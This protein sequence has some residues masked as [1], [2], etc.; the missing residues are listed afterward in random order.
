MGVSLFWENERKSPPGLA[1]I[2]FNFCEAFQVT[3]QLP[4]N[5]RAIRYSSETVESFN[6]QKFEKRSQRWKNKLIT[7][8]SVT[9]FWKIYSNKKNWQSLNQKWL[10]SIT[11]FK[12][13]KILV[14]Y[15]SLKVS[16]RKILNNNWTHNCATSSFRSTSVRFLNHYQVWEAVRALSI[17]QGIGLILRGMKSFLPQTHSKRVN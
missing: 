7:S 1:E 16:H 13:N 8:F 9:D 4:G 17:I 10:K 3:R 6:R 12:S 2:K 5:R 11:N 15:M 14:F